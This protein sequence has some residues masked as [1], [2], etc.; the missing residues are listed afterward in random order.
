[1]FIQTERTTDSATLKFLPGR[2]VMEKGSANFTEASEA[3]RSP[4]ATDLFGLDRIS[5]VLLGSDFITVTK[6]DDRDW[7][8]I[9]PQ[10][11][12]AIMEHFQSGEPVITGDAAEAADSTEPGEGDA[13]SAQ[14]KELIDTRVRPAVAYLIPAVLPLLWNIAVKSI[15]SKY[16]DHRT[17]FPPSGHSTGK[18][19]GLIRSSS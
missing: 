14:I 12:G 13:I 5:G 18:S 8:I 2:P 4:L 11:L 19:H 3:R 15:K 10:I 16:I 17:A 6:S 1:M 7:D 9:K